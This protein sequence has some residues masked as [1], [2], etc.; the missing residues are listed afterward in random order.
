MSQLK[1]QFLQE[2]RDLHNTCDGPWLL[3]GDFNLILHTRDKNNGRLHR[4]MMRCFWRAIDD[5][6]LAEMHLP[7]H[8]YTWS[9]ERDNPTLE[10]LDRAFTSI[11]W[12]EHYPMHAF[13]A[14]SLDCS[15]HAPLLLLLSSEPGLN[16]DST[17]SSS[18]SS[19]RDSSTSC[20]LIGRGP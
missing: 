12:L 4:G 1:A 7:G 19:S 13:H 17:L 14:I 20:A 9:N 8:L 10:R 11:K 18:G 3:C 16:P 6:G 5:L 15:D 2:L